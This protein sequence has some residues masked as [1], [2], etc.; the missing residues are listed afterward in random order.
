MIK[1]HTYPTSAEANQSVVESYGLLS[2]TN[3]FL[4]AKTVQQRNISPEHQEE[5]K[6]PIETV[7]NKSAL[8]LSALPFTSGNPVH[9]T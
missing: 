3:H 7:N 1:T 9:R 4:S 6:K 5:K 2:E 8:T